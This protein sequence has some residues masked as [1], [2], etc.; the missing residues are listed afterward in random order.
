MMLSCDGAWANDH[1]SKAAM[2]FDYLKNIFG[3]ENNFAFS[4]TKITP[5][6]RALIIIACLA[7]GLFLQNPKP[8]MQFNIKKKLL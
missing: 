7:A 8:I 2:L 6:V 3:Q 4:S 1:K 5:N